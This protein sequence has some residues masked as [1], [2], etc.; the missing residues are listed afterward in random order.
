MGIIVA[1][2]IKSK[3]SGLLIPSAYIRMGDLSLRIM[4]HGDKFNILARFQVFYN[5]QRIEE[6]AEPVDT[7]IVELKEQDNSVFDD[8]AN[9]LYTELK[10]RYDASNIIDD[11]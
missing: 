1:D 7:F 5:K 8:P 11:I 9:L 10:T 3:E 4:R 6:G 2:E